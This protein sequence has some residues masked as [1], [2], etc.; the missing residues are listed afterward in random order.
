M[1]SFQTIVPV[2]NML[3]P[4]LKKAITSAGLLIATAT[5]GGI[6]GYFISESQITSREVIVYQWQEKELI[7][8][9]WNK[10]LETKKANCKNETD[11]E[12]IEGKPYVK[13]E[14]LTTENIPSKLDEKVKE[15]EIIL[16]KK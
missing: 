8:L 10:M 4:E 3:T 12:F 16:K 2:F 9:L 6:G 7:T 15:Y 14:G 5:A 13:L 11:C 1:S